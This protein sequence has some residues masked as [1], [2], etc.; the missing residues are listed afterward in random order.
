M[1]W[2]L[3]FVVTVLVA[4]PAL[5]LAQ[6]QLTIRGDGTVATAISVGARF[7]G[8]RRAT[9]SD[10]CALPCGVRVDGAWWLRIE[11][12]TGPARGAPLAYDG[13]LEGDFRLR[14]VSHAS[15]RWLGGVGLVLGLVLTVAAVAVGAW[16]A[17]DELG[18]IVAGRQPPP[19]PGW[20]AFA[21]LALG[22]VTFDILGTVGLSTDDEASLEPLDPAR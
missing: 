12:A 19:N 7:P 17:L 21:A 2:V 6:T 13:A 11:T 20:W 5:A 14:F 22:G 3:S 16:L 15:E 8:E 18:A 1:S 9:W 4:S 10:P